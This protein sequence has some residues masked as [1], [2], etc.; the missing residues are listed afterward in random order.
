M[1]SLPVRYQEILRYLI[2][3]TFRNEIQRSRVFDLI[4]RRKS[5]Q[6]ET[7]FLR[8]ALYRMDSDSTFCMDIGNPHRFDLAGR[9]KRSG[10]ITQAGNENGH[11]QFTTP[12][13]RVILGQLLF[14]ASLALNNLPKV[15]DFEEFLT[16]S[17]RRMRPSVI[18]ESFSKRGLHSRVY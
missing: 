10:I 7:Q 18:R 14:T 6:N 16:I 8:E 12:L 4:N 15:D 9:F 11:L 5:N 13:V 3:P 17:I 2:S 1:G